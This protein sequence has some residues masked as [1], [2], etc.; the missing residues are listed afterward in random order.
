MAGPAAASEGKPMRRVLD[1]LYL[2]CLWLSA[3]C[4]VAIAVLVGLQL[5][6]R[7]FDL[8]TALIGRQP[9]GI[10]ILSL[11]EICGALLA[12]ASFLALAATLHAGAHIRVTM[13]LAALPERVRRFMEIWAF[14]AAALFSA[15]IAWQLAL[16]AYYSWKFNEVSSGVVPIKL[17]Y[18]QA[19]MAFGAAMLVIA[20][21]DELVNVMRRGRPSF[22]SAEDAISLGKEG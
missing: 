14:G 18:P 7:I 16:F 10:V 1:G 2:F 5:A 9:S 20:L 19:V 13:L 15:Y 11:A 17:A 21:V 22:R 4:L 12:A 3:L 8:L 6:G